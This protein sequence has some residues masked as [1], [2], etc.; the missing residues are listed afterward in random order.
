MSRKL[1]YIVFGLQ[2]IAQCIYWEIIKGYPACFMCKGYRWFYIGITMMSL[3]YRFRRSNRRS[4]L[5]LSALI[6]GETAWGLWDVLQKSQIFPQKCSHV[7]RL[8]E[9]VLT[10]VTQCSSSSLFW[11][12]T[13]INFLI[14][15][16]VSLII[17]RSIFLK[18]TFLFIGISLLSLVDGMA[19]QKLDPEFEKTLQQKAQKAKKM[20]E[21]L[22]SEL[23]Q[24]NGCNGKCNP[25]QTTAPSSN[26]LKIYMSFSV[27]ESIWVELDKDLQKQQGVFVLRGLPNNSFQEFSMKVLELRKKGV[28]SNIQIDPKAFEQKSI[29][30][31]PTFVDDQKGHRVSGTVS[32]AHVLNLFQDQ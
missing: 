8:S 26:G 27:P 9:E 32:V 19:A 2:G 14:S 24:S 17:I 20:S 12:P 4:F 31:V 22:K 30:C 7:A 13:L 6:L 3:W 11:S 29:R 10:T 21:G 15:V 28:M 16:G 5:K 25:F 23:P 1:L 18:R